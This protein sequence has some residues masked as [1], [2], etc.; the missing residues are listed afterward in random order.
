MKLTPLA[1]FFYVCD[2]NI[3]DELVEKVCR[4]THTSSV[5]IATAFIYVYLCVFIFQH[6]L[7]SSDIERKAF[8]QYVHQ[9][10]IRYESKYNLI[11]QKDLL[12]IRIYR[13]LEKIDEI[14]NELLLDVSRGGTFF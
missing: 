8:L 3:D 10:S 4:M 1:F 2:I 13:Y 7:P 6:D 9:L 5:T 12:S 14:N 11:T